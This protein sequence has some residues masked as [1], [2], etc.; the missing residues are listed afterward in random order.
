MTIT[1]LIALATEL[2]IPFATS[3]D[4]TSGEV[5]AALVTSSGRVYTG[6]CI[7]TECG[8]GFCAEHAAI[9]EMMKARECVIKMIVA[10]D[11][12]G[13]ILAPCG[14]CRE[15]MWQVADQNRDTAV[16]LTPEKSVLLA[17]LLPFR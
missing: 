16:V 5:A 11:H 6:V 9:A 14:R 2:A 17:D 1:D 7:D 4:C 8:I 10:V 15:L 3:T 13:T 12:T